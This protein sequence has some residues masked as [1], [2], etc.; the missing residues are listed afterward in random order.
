MHDLVGAKR[1]PWWYRR[2]AFAPERPAVLARLRLHREAEPVPLDLG[3][4]EREMTDPHNRVPDDGIVRIHLRGSGQ[5]TAILR[6]Q[7]TR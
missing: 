3:L 5:L 1:E 7:V 6:S 2:D 4:V